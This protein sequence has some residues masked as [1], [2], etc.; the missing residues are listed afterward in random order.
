MKVLHLGVFDRNIGDNIALAHIE[1][2]IAK[3]FPGIKF[4]RVSLEEFWHRNN[5]EWF[6]RKIYNDFVDDIDFIL[7]GG[8]GLLEYGGYERMKS[9]YKL[10]FY[11]QTLKFIKKPILYYGLGV[12]IFRGGIDYSA[13]AKRNLQEAID[14]SKAFSV[15]NDGSYKKLKDWI[16]VDTT[17]VDIV[18][19]PGLLHLDRFGIKR[20]HTVSKLGFQPAINNSKGI[21]NKRFGN[22]NNLQTIINKFK[23]TKVFPHTIKDF[24]FGKPVISLNE[25]NNHY[26]RIDKLE[27]YLNLYSQIDYVVAMRGHGQMISIGMNIPGLYLSTQDKVRDFSV[28]NGFEDYDIDIRDEYWFEKLEIAQKRLEE[29]KSK[30]LKDWYE[31]RDEFINKC[32]KI[33]DEWIIKNINEVRSL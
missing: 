24:K 18:P 25:F 5:H 28:E 16:G 6:T 12:N 29:P 14:H 15:R 27:D 22:S 17:K 26:K 10:P 20:K 9:H 11:N 23:K 30:Y 1:Y 4:A 31:I 8:G 13:K 7:V 32:H 33:D 2:S 21:N 3:H 19:D